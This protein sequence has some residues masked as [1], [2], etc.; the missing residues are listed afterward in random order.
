MIGWTRRQGLSGLVIV[1][2]FAYRA[3]DPKVLRTLGDPVGVHND[4]AIA[5]ISQEAAMT[6]VAWGSD[7]RL[8]N[9]STQ[10][11]RRLDSPVCLG[12]TSSGEPRHPLY[13]RADA[14]LVPWPAT[15][16]AGRPQ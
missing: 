16:S 15:P 1:N 13:V 9:R 3:T 10:V 4:R 5:K 8:H 2:L 7:G 11:R 12:V 6:F 14:E